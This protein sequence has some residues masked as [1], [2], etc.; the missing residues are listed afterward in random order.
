MTL[1]LHRA[2][3]EA[4]RERDIREELARRYDGPLPPEAAVSFDAG[5]PWAVQLRNRRL[6]AWRSVRRIGHDCAFE[7]RMMLATNSAVH[8]DRWRR[9][10]GDLR[11]ALESWAAFREWSRPHEVEI[12]EAAE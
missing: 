2:R 12:R 3:T 9:L 6:L 10:R 7:R 4:R 11:H 1:D 8:L 5:E